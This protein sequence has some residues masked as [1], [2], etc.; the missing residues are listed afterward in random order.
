MPPGTFGIITFCT[1]VYSPGAIGQANVGFICFLRAVVSKKGLEAC[2]AVLHDQNVQLWAK[3]IDRLCKYGITVNGS[4][5]SKTEI[6]QHVSGP[7]V[8]RWS[9][10]TE[11]AYRY[12]MRVY[13]VH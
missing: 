7:F 5:N 11:S 4:L 9:L 10:E 6:L 8:C 12:G 3:V 13:K 1:Y 2:R